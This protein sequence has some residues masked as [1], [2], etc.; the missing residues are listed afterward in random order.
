MK[1]TRSSKMET[2]HLPS[3]REKIE[4][5]TQSRVKILIKMTSK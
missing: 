2:T 5:E 1:K 3:T 4:M